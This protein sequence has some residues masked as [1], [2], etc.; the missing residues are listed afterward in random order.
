MA[1]PLMV[2]DVVIRSRGMRKSR[3]KPLLETMN[4]SIN[5]TLSRTILTGGS[6]LLV[7]LCLLIWGGEV[8]RGFAFVM[9]VGILIGTYS[10]IYVAS[11]FV[12]LWEQLFGVQG[13]WRKGKAGSLSRGPDGR[14]EPPA[15]I[16]PKTGEA[17]P[18]RSRQTRKRA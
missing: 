13:K 10:S 14:S 2:M 11:P 4:E 5:Q 9:F 16:E 17:P 7:L 1:G 3:R 18:R 6:T 12:L 8:L 15:R